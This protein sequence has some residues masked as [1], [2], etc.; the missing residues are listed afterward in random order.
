MVNIEHRT[1]TS[2]HTHAIIV[3]NKKLL[4]E[5]GFKLSEEYIVL[6]EQG[7]ITIAKELKSAEVK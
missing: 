5:H 7:K 1:I 4:T 6:Y 2:T 3:L